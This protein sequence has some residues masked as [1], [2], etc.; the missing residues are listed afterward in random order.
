MQK[1]S[2]LAEGSTWEMLT[3]H[4]SLV[5]FCLVALKGLALFIH[6]LQF[7]TDLHF[8]SNGQ[9]PAEMSCEK[10]VLVAS[11]QVEQGNIHYL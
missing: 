6:A 8:S 11:G 10:L 4:P 9:F 7:F 2:A 3:A 1:S 5:P